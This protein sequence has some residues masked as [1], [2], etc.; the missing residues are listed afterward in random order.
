MDDTSFRFTLNTIVCTAKVRLTVFSILG[1]IR[2]NP[3]IGRAWFP[4]PIE[5]T[6]CGTAHGSSNLAPLYL[7]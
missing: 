2:E 4:N 7:H 5:P 6:N 3:V 1:S